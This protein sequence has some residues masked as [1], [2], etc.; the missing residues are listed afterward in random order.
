MPGQPK[1]G[2]VTACFHPVP[3]GWILRKRRDSEPPRLRIAPC[4][5]VL[6]LYAGSQKTAMGCLTYSRQLCLSR[7][8]LYIWWPGSAIGTGL[9]NSA[10]GSGPDPLVPQDC[11]STSLSGPDGCG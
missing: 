1:P 8:Y 2:E 6:P 11:S 3:E 9:G 4:F 7:E 10:G 5:P